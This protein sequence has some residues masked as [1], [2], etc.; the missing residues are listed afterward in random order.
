MLNM[1]NT[2]KTTEIKKF[3]FITG[4]GITYSPEHKEVSNSQVLGIAS[5]L[6]VEEA[7]EKLLEENSWITENEFNLENITHHELK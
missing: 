3:I 4:D 5:G 1:N 6:S 7:K 2:E